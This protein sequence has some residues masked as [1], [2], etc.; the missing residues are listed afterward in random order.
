M[1]LL[2]LFAAVLHWLA[3]VAGCFPKTEIRFLGHEVFRS[4]GILTRQRGVEA[5][6]TRGRGSSEIR[7]GKYDIRHTMQFTWGDCTAGP[8]PRSYWGVSLSR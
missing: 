7:D 4:A 8:N 2:S 6:L 5:L 3:K 1:R